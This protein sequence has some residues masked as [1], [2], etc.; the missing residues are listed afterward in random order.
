VLA[1]LFRAGAIEVT[2]GGQRFDSYQDA[3]SRTPF[4]NNPAFR[5]ALFTPAR[6]IDLKTLTQAVEA[7]EDL[8]GTTVEV[9]KGAIAAALKKW[10]TREMQ[11]ILPV[12]A[13]AKANGLPVLD[14]I[15]EYRT[16]LQAIVDSVAEDCIRVL[17]GEGTTLKESCSTM[18]KIRAA[19]TDKNLE[20]LKN[21][22]QVSS[23][24]WPVLES[25]GL[26]GV[27]SEHAHQLREALASADFYTVLD[28]LRTHLKPLS[29]AY[30]ELYTELHTNRNKAYHNAVEAV[31]ARPEWA[32]LSHEAQVALIG[33]LS[34]RACAELDLVA[35]GGTCHQCNA[36]VSQMESDLAAL[37]GL[38]TQALVRLQELTAPKEKVVRV[39]LASFFNNGLESE[40]EIEK[41]IDQL[42]TQLLKL[43]AEGVKIILE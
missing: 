2:S 5:N 10:A 41:A 42:K 28:D 12:E 24:V 22:R 18:Q 8:V 32:K 6:M 25:H 11:D 21:A 31:A 7:Y 15:S 29:K 3:R 34:S 23:R 20:L 13:E 39:K 14:W 33:P 26:D 38:K 9:E 43:M 1:V 36:T 16:S 35:H 40:E 27:L 37:D 19:T 17:V 30:A 4:V